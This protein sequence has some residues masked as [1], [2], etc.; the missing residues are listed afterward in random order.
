MWWGIRR[1]GNQETSRYEDKGGCFKA[2]LTVSAP[3][4]VTVKVP[5]LAASGVAGV[6]VT[7]A[8]RSVRDA[9]TR[10]GD[11]GGLGRG[12]DGVGLGGN[13]DAGECEVSVHDPVLRASVR[14]PSGDA[15]VAALA[16]VN[17]RR[18]EALVPTPRVSVAV[19]GQMTRIAVA[20]GA[21]MDT[22]APSLA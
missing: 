15:S 19:L 1:L 21:V 18:T 10:G 12:G 4:A 3:G 14:A 7:V 8:A 13:G 5:V 22:V 6:T 20:A 17:R 16:G 11:G 9:L 2:T